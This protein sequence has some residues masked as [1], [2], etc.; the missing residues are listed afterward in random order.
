MAN[1]I[2]RQTVLNGARNV[3]IKLSIVGDG[4]G[5]ETATSA[6]D[7]SAF[8]TADAKIMSV[9]GS[10]SGFSLR[11]LWDATADVDAA[12]FDAGAEVDA[13]Y[14]R[15]GGLINN[16]GSGKTG[17]IMFTTLGLGAGDAGHLVIELRKRGLAA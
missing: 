9:K 10:L 12:A 14:R 2:T 17:D 1:T 13:C 4:S 5:E 11:L 16:A 3:V 8:D 15:I 7:A 6:F